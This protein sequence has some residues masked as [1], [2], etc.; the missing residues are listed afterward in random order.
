M[1]VHPIEIGGKHGYL[2]GARNGCRC[3][4]ST[5]VLSVLGKASNKQLLVTDFTNE[6]LELCDTNPVVAAQVVNESNRRTTFGKGLR[7]NE[8][9]PRCGIQQI[10]RSVAGLPATALAI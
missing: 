4:S 10:C 2:L 6:Q 9:Y 7:K 5:L 1:P 3:S 8:K